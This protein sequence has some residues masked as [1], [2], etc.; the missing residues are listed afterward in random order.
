MT[1]SPPLEKSGSSI[2]DAD[3]FV[4]ESESSSINNIGRDAFQLD[5]KPGLPPLASSERPAYEKD[6]KGPITS[7]LLGF[8][9]LR[10]RN[11]FGLDEV[12][13]QPSGK[14][15]RHAMWGVALIAISTASLRYRS[16]RVLQPSRR[17]REH[18]GL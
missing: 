5:I 6:D 4:L 2:K 7:A 18:R 9:G 15:D 3:A 10:S 14:S 13:T 17:L 12:A 11:K 16:G 8:F 1:S